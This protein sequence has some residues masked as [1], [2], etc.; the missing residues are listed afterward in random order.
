VAAELWLREPTDPARL[1]GCGM[2]VRQPPWHWDAEWPPLLAAL[3]AAVG[4]AEAGE[5]TRTI[6]LTDE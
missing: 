3:L 2:L 1:N 6:R 5:A 4:A